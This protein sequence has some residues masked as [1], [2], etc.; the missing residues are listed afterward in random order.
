MSN[1]E[2]SASSLAAESVP[3]AAAHDG[4]PNNGDISSAVAA[5]E[6]EAPAQEGEVALAEDAPGAKIGEL[7]RARFSCI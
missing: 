7:K 5:S 1:K 2:E 4:A 3:N 6:N